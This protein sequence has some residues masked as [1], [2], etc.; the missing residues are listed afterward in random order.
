[1][2]YRNEYR[3]STLGRKIPDPSARRESARREKD[4]MK[5][6]AQNLPSVLQGARQPEKTSTIMP[7]Q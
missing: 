5:A 4:R 7:Y 2:K 1:M 6:V 3:T